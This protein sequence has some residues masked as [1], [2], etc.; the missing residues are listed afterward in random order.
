MIKTSQEAYLA[1][2]QAAM[3]KLSFAGAASR[4]LMRGGL[5]RG[6]GYAAGGL[7][8]GA[9]GYGVYKGIKDGTLF[10]P[11]KLKEGILSGGAGGFL[12]RHALKQ[13]KPIPEMKER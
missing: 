9:L 4:A 5:R 10:D 12:A 2:R 13:F 1:G 8:T 6:L 7:G 11:E 3:E